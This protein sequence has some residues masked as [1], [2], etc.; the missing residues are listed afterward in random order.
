MQLDM[1]IILSFVR[2]K[3]ERSKSAPTQMGRKIGL[4]F[5]E[6]HLLHKMHVGGKT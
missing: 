3:I 1:F 5:P 4:T 2:F 6:R